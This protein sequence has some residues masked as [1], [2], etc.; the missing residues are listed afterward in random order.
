VAVDLPADLVDHC[1]GGGVVVLTGAGA[2]TESGIPDYRSPGRPPRT[3]LQHR[4][5]V[6]SAAARARYWARSA[7]GWPV[8]SRAT[9]N[10]AHTAIAALEHR[11]GVAALITQNVDGLHG[12]AGSRELCE[13]HGSIHRV[14]C[15]GCGVRTGRDAIQARLLADNP[16]LASAAAAPMPDGDADL[17]PELTADLAVPACESCGDG[18]L[19]PDVVLFGD[20]VARPVVDQCYGWVDA[21][22]VLVVVGSSLAVFSGYRFVVRARDRGVPI[23][24]VNRGPTR[25]DA[26]AT[27]RLD[28][29]AGAA[30]T[31]LATALGAL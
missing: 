2:S 31:A 21:A 6:A 12:A 9:P 4:E 20:N 24:I 1:T 16:R 23:A 19:K 14:V 10:P 8:M 11:G 29:A 27:W 18:V 5:F 26:L 3:P 17:A 28:A 7:I 15:L 25:G 22:R 13:L 30:V